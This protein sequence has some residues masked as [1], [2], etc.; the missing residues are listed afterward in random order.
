MVPDEVSRIVSGCNR[1]A[2]LFSRDSLVRVVVGDRSTLIGARLGSTWRGAA[3][4]RAPETS[5]Y[6]FP[7]AHGSTSPLTGGSRERFH[8]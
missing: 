7:R 2:F 1:I 8:A 3:L 5:R 6:L 4:D